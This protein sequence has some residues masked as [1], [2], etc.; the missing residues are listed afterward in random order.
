[1]KTTQRIIV[2]AGLFLFNLNTFSQDTNFWI[3]VCFGQSNMEG[4]PGIEEQDK[5]PVDDRF[6][7]FAAV[8]FPKLDRKK[9]PTQGTFSGQKQ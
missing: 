3:F 7:V 6:Q 2:L 1:M 5:S 4:F 8:D 9:G